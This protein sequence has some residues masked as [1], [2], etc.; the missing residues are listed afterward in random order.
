ML[1]PFKMG[2]I[3]KGTETI[4]KDYTFTL[5]LDKVHSLALC[6]FVAGAVLEAK[7]TGRKG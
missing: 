1:L 6:L 7:Q 2:S 3:Q 5:D 4:C